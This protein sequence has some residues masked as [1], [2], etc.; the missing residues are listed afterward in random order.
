MVRDGR[1]KILATME[2][3]E[4]VTLA[5]TNGIWTAAMQHGGHA[6]VWRFRRD[7]VDNT[8]RLI[9]WQAWQKDTPFDFMAAALVLRVL[10][11]VFCR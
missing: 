9:A 4:M 5:C 3:S 11:E 7:Q 8:R 1:P 10:R 2:G 6:F